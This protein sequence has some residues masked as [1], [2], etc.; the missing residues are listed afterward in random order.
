MRGVRLALLLGLPC[1]LGLIV[2]AELRNGLF[3][4]CLLVD[5]RTY[6]DMAVALFQGAY[7]PGT[8]FWQPPFYSIAVSL[9]YRLSGPSPDAVR[10]LQVVLHATS[11]LLVFV[12]GRRVFGSRPAWIAWGIYAAYGPLLLA[13]QQLLGPVLAITLMLIAI[14]MLTSERPSLTQL[15]IGGLALG[16]ASITVATMLVLVPLLL[17]YIARQQRPAKGLALLVLLLSIAVGPA[18]ITAWNAHESGEAVFIS[19]NGGINFWLG[20]NPEYERTVAIRPGREWSALTIEPQRAGARGFGGQSDY[21]YRKGLTWAAAAPLEAARLYAHKAR[22]LLRGDEIFRNEAIYPYCGESR[23]LRLLLWVGGVGF[24]FG[25]L[26]PLA[27]VGMFGGA[28]GPRLR[29][30]LLAALSIYGL[31]VIAFFVTG[32]YR[33]PLVPFLAVFAG[34]AGDRL[35]AMRQGTRDRIGVPALTLGVIVL[36]LCNLGLPAMSLEWNSDARRDLGYWH[37]LAGRRDQAQAEY[38]RAAALD[39]NNW[40]A[41][42]NLAGL[43]LEAGKPLE[44]LPLY[45]RVLAAFPEDRG[46]RANLG[47][48]YLSMNEVYLAG[49]EYEQLLA[50]NPNDG[51]A[52]ENLARC[53]A[54]A[55]ELESNFMARDPEKLLDAMLANLREAPENRYLLRRMRPLFR[56]SGRDA[57]LSGFRSDEGPAPPPSS[58]TV[59]DTPAAR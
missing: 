59:V 9:L 18:W 30:L 15:A 48:L 42:N 4:D 34:N 8:P 39:P 10:L 52:K 55:A 17:F 11:A 53:D 2:F 46:V 3:H 56:A 27:T 12:L 44:A 32:R 26:L 16:L 58:G 33:L 29:R 31:G 7:H 45:Q 20:N 5:A 38:R 47:A 21:F 40:E 6:H 25:L 43:L 28:H 50:A 1:L 14:V 51:V 24:P 36:L 23:L 19:Y 22:L 41:L 54:G 37:Q 49:N 35:L 57:E 13:A